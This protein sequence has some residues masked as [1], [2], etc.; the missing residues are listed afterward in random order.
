MKDVEFWALI[1]KV[2]GVSDHMLVKLGYEL[3]QRI[4][5]RSYL[6]KKEITDIINF[7]ELLCQKI[8]QLYLPKVA[9]V[10]VAMVYVVEN[11]QIK[12]RYIS[13][14][15]FIDFRAAIVSLGKDGFES[16]LRLKEQEEIL[17]YELK[18]LLMGREDLVYL[19]DELIQE[20]EVEIE[21]DY[22][23]DGDYDQLIK[24]IEWDKINDKY[25]KLIS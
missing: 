11:K 6:G 15:G 25:S 23:L 1:E 21:L 18:E 4:L 5:I 7:H 19:S 10:F 24:E 14:D 2:Q 16:F 12:S 9:E 3:T 13:T 17:E 20:R 8:R 22:H